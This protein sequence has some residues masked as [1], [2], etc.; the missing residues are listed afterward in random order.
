MTAAGQVRSEIVSRRACLK[1]LPNFD[2][3]KNVAPVLYD[4]LPSRF[5]KKEYIVVRLCL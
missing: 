3:R 2:N 4:L 1:P 5:C